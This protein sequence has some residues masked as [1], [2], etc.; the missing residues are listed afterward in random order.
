MTEWK[1]DIRLGMSIG[2]I[3]IVTIVLVDVGVISL[4]AIR[5][6]SIGTF[7]TGLAVLV[8]L[9]LLGLIGYWLYGLAR[10]KY[11]LDRNALVIH[12]RPTEQ[13]VP[14]GQI[15]RVLTGDEIKGHIRFYGGRWP[16][17]CVGYGEVPGAGP[18]LFHA[19]APPR[20]QIYVVT[21]S[22]TYGISPAD[23]EGFL[24]SLQ[25]RLQM[26]PTQIME[27][28]SKRP[29]FLNWPI[30]QDWL[31]LALLATGFLAVLALIGLLCFEFPTL[32]RLVPLHF[33]AVGNPDRLGL[34]GQIFIIPLIGLLALLLNGVLGW[35]AYRYERVASYL[36]WGGTILIQVLVWAA[37]LGI[38]GQV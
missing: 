8:S 5:P 17:H 16:G 26:G 30:W 2:I 22:L 4:A 33:D 9:G 24:E 38:L 21:P 23:R 13:I 18:A 6:L 25:K 37:A 10:S 28:S 27:Q 36:L 34:R 12:W 31:G 11:L 32:P 7:I 1:T 3:L 19:T 35:V 14:T 15:E 20:H 29:G